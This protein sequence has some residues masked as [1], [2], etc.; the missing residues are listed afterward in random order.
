MITDPKRLIEKETGYTFLKFW[1]DF[2]RYNKEYI[3]DDGGCVVNW[4]TTKTLKG[5]CQVAK[6]YKMHRI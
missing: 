1:D 2:T 6:H 3:D 5:L 4:G